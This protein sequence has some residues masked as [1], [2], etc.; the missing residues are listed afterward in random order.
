[1]YTLQQQNTLLYSKAMYAFDPSTFKVIPN[2]DPH[3]A[4]TASLDVFTITRRKATK[5][6]AVGYGTVL[7]YRVPS[8]NVT[9]QDFLQM[10]Q[11]P[12]LKTRFYTPYMWDG[13]EMWGTTNF[14]HMSTLVDKMDPLLKAEPNLP[15]NLEGWYAVE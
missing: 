5:R 11:T 9:Y 3:K 7:W 12:N 8:L 10:W 13:E 2:S 15:P 1:M 6:R 14:W 4:P